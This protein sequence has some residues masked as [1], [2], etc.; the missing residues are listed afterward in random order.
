M[1]D[2]MLS[3]LRCGRDMTFFGREK[4]QLGQTGWFFGDLPNL[5]AG[6]LEV[7]LYRCDGCGKL[8]FFSTVG[9]D[10]AEADDGGM[11]G[12]EI[13]KRVCPACGHS[14]DIDY[15]KCPFCRFDYLQA[16]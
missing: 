15:P 6:A 1:N 8:E 7:D 10:D 11:G 13:A 14:H 16:R 4:I 9:A 5:L 12:G 3:C 2:K